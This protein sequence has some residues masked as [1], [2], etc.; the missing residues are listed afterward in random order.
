MFILFVICFS[1]VLCPHL[2]PLLHL[3]GVVVGLLRLWYLWLRHL[4]KLLLLI[5]FEQPTSLREPQRCEGVRSLSDLGTWD[6]L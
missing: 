2:L 3:L 4:P 5:K 1:L 6:I